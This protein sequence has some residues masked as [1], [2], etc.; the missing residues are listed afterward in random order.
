MGEQ[1]PI[2][3]R[4]RIT[5]GLGAAETDRDLA[6]LDDDERH[7]AA[8][9]RFATDRRDFIAAH[10][11]AR[12][13]LSTEA[14]AVSPDGWRFDRVAA[15]KP[16]VRPGSDGH[17]PPVFSLSHGKGLVGCAVAPSGA[18]GLDVEGRVDFDVTAV[19]GTVCSADERA[20]LSG[21]TERDRGTRFLDF[22]TLKEAYGKAQG[23]G[24]AIDLASASFDLRH[25]GSI[26]LRPG[27]D[28]ASLWH[29]AL[30][31][32]EAGSRL[33]VAIACPEGVVPPI[34]AALIG[35][36]GSVVALQV[37]RQGSGEPG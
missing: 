5:A 2:A 35:L 34:D 31:E 19:A 7:A 6:L 12:R 18:L 33:A 1:R 8:R 3:L 37:L 15:G 10:A 9:L 36:D 20:Q 29:F 22:W 21:L 30:F 13:M 32:P 25:P 14:S 27:C 4:C 17:P 24:V 16:F 28:A 23:L 26:G 11:L